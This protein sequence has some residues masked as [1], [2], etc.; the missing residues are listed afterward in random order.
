MYQQYQQNHAPLITM[1]FLL[2][3]ITRCKKEDVF[4]F[5][6]HFQPKR[7]Q[8]QRLSRRALIS[9]TW[10]KSTNSM[11]WRELVTVIRVAYKYKYEYNNAL[12]FRNHVYNNMIHSVCTLMSPRWHAIFAIASDMT[13]VFAFLVWLIF[14]FNW[15]YYLEYRIASVAMFGSDRP[16]ILGFRRFW[17]AAVYF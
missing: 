5:R 8:N 9:V 13:D 14:W 17:H 1:R 3:L 11:C 10:R 12:S 2:T 4:T 16:I 15:F 6:G 7:Q